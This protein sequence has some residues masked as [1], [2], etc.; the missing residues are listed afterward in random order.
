MLP[1]SVPQQRAKPHHGI[2]P[3]NGAGVEGECNNWVEEL[4]VKPKSVEANFMVR[5]ELETCGCVLKARGTFRKFSRCFLLGGIG[6][7]E[8]CLYLLLGKQDDLR[9]EQFSAKLTK[10]KAYWHGDLQTLPR[11]LRA[12]PWKICDRHPTC[13]AFCPLISLSL[14]AANSFSRTG[15]GEA[16]PPFGRQCWSHN[17][18]SWVRVFLHKH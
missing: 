17:G 8:G 1:L 10:C 6:S 3:R 7:L 2:N 16:F 13:C 11:E 12:L 5:K 14:S 18:F 9:K 15:R 4:A